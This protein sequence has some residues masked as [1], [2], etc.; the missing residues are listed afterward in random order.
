MLW[1]EEDR[2]S[3]RIRMI[4]TFRATKSGCDDW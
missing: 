2:F 3:Y 4:E 1:K